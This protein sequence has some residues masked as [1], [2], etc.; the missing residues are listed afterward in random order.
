MVAPVYIQNARVLFSW[1][2]SETPNFSLNLF[3]HFLLSKTFTSHG[4]NYIR[5]QTEHT[6][7]TSSFY[8]CPATTLL[9]TPGVTYITSFLSQ[10]FFRVLW[11]W[12]NHQMRWGK[13][14]NLSDDFNPWLGGREIYITMPSKCWLSLAVV[15]SVVRAGFLGTELVRLHKAT[16]TCFNA[17]L[18]LSWN[19]SWILNTKKTRF[20]FAL[21]PT[22]YV[23]SPVDNTF[24]I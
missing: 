8:S 6:Q 5:Y 2:W 19:S 23:A 13:K 9:L 22:N 21:G 3:I 11:V 24:Q 4:S 1:V 7:Q 10:Y 17:L 18:S 12:W 15:I 20:H 14:Q 16:W